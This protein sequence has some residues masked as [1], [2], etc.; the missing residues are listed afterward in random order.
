MP[1]RCDPCCTTVQA[2]QA[3]AQEARRLAEEE[4]LR[5]H[6]RNLQFK[7][8]ELQERTPLTCQVCHMWSHVLSVM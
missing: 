4:D 1:G 8:S 5:E 2:E 3:A 7:V 6:R